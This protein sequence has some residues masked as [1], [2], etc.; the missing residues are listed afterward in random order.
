MT[1]PTPLPA[2]P[3]TPIFHQ[4]G[5]TFGGDLRT[6]S[7]DIHQ[8]NVVNI[9]RDSNSNTPS[10][11]QID[12][13]VRRT[14]ADGRLNVERLSGKSLPL[15][16]C[17]VNLGI[18][19]HVRDS[20]T[21]LTSN[22]SGR[23]EVAEQQSRFSL[24]VRLKVETPPKSRRISLSTLFEPQEQEDST[25]RR[26]N[27]VLI[28]GRAGMGKTTLC[29]KI[30]HEVHENG[31]WKDLYDRVI[32]LPLRKLKKT[33]SRTVV[34]LLRDEFMITGLGERTLEGLDKLVHDERTLLLLDGLDE[35]SFALK[36]D[37]DGETIL[38]YLVSQPHVIITSRP[39]GT[40]I[41]NR[42]PP[43]LEL[44]TVG[45]F[46]QQIEQYLQ[47]VAGIQTEEIRSFIQERPLVQSLAA[48]PIQL[49]AICYTWNAKTFPHDNAT[50]TTLYLMISQ[51]LWK[52]SALRLGKTRE[53]E[54]ITKQQLDHWS[55]RHLEESV[56]A[57]IAFL[58][59][60]GFRGLC[61]EVVEFSV[62]DIET[63]VTSRQIPGDK[64]VH[65]AFLRVS[66]SSVEADYR[67]V[68]FIHLTFQEFFAAQYFV[69][70]WMSNEAL[71]LWEGTVDGKRSDQSTAFVTPEEFV[72]S[73]KHDD[74][75][76]VFWRFVV[77]LLLSE[78]N[79]EQLY[80][81]LDTLES[82]PIDL[83]GLVHQRLV[84]HC[85]S[86][87][88]AGDNE[89]PYRVQQLE[90]RFLEWASCEMRLKRNWTGRL[91]STSLIW[92]AECSDYVLKRL[93]NED[94]T[95]KEVLEVLC[96]RSNISSNILD[97]VIQKL[98]ESTSKD[99]R[100][101]TI[102]IVG[103]HCGQDQKGKVVKLS[104]DMQ[105]LRTTSW[106]ISHAWRGTS[107]LLEPAIK[108]LVGL[109][110]DPD[111]EVRSNAADALGG[112]ATLPNMAVEALVRLLQDPDLDKN[113]R[114]ETALALG[115][116][117][118]LSNTTIETLIRLLLDL[119]KN[120]RTETAYTLR[121]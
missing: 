20:D 31:L 83:I 94:E 116:Q 41:L 80:R 12:E 21:G 109:L 101:L 74:R 71:P 22:E 93:L 14:Y 66:D 17:F 25:Q 34:E 72:K 44:E 8:G 64:I 95:E 79:K 111:N 10:Y 29:K 4:C 86:E 1:S 63:L 65:L 120:V 9:N 23:K 49:D 59:E 117:A 42:K 92:E 75:Y 62:E 28:W 57:E 13:V 15:E 112:Q 96:R 106:E 78:Q 77:G 24:A 81:F 48:I 43:D 60:L 19:D 76:D 3:Q 7:G 47:Q 55:R 54:L 6:V 36:Q 102:Q 121:Q 113:V 16:Y 85:L 26:P 108:T 89:L 104:H 37:S 67:T 114:I 61:E 97:K 18:I 100:S 88:R 58:Q 11:S 118:T 35:V 110:Q 98:S 5:S 51:S 115:K 103:Q 38:H 84:V 107:R 46:P 99:I 32:W 91:Q 50:M 73:G 52:S 90:D 27:R 87:L 82:E 39:H 119:N 105:C 45:F 53:G 2:H 40:H 68:H 33:R 69:R 70:H 56:E 30:V